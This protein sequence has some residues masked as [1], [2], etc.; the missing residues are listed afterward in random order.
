MSGGR[1]DGQEPGA[2]TPDKFCVMFD[3]P[4]VVT[5]VTRTIVWNNTYGNVLACELTT[6]ENERLLIHLTKTA[7]ESLGVNAKGLMG[8]LGK[9]GGPTK[10]ID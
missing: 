1:R 5:K 9:F 10:K 4:M 8:A 3:K 2:K 7:A 6:E